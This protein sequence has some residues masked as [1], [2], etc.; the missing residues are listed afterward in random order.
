MY[1]LSLT[2]ITERHKNLTIKKSKVLLVL[3]RCQTL[4]CF[5]TLSLTRVTRLIRNPSQQMFSYY[6]FYFIRCPFVITKF[7]YL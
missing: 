4:K 3:S 2:Q 1:L 7:H 5:F 6:V